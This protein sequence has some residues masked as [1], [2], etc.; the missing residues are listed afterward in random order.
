M[1]D[2]KA[3]KKKTNKQ[4]NK[5]PPQ[6]QRAKKKENNI[7]GTGLTGFRIFCQRNLDSR[8][9]LLVGFPIPWVVFRIPK[10]RI[11]DSANKI[12]KDFGIWIPSQVSKD[13]TYM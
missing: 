7:P 10:A 6:H 1:E 2:N 9:Q 3:L 13:V 11:P 8:F 5:P 12:F 4:T